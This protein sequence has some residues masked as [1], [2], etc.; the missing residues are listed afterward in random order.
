MNKWELSRYLIDAKKSVDSILFINEHIKK[1]ANID[2]RGRVASLRRDFYIN[3]CVVLDKSFPKDKKKI[4]EDE[5]ISSIYYERDK[6]GAHKDE[7]YNPKEY[8]S[9]LEMADDMKAQLGAVRTLCK[10]YL[11]ENVTLDY[12][13]HDRELF[14]LLYC[15][16]YEK[17]E[18]LKKRKHPIYGVPVEGDNAVVKKVFHDTEDARTLTETEK[19]DYAVILEDG[20]NW[21]ESMQNHQDFCIKLNVLYGQNTWC[22]FNEDIFNQMMQLKELGLFDEFC[23]PIMPDFENEELMRKIQEIMGVKF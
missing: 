14:R 5:V 11:P 2:I 20:L 15:M 21:Y 10:D 12:V 1:I 8:N 23:V 3:C 9:F 16:T 22:T 7:N 6:N 19:N 17:E 18:E 4:C 13:P